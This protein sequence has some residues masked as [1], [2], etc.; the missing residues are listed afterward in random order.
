MRARQPRSLAIERILK[1]HEVPLPDD[2]VLEDPEGSPRRHI[3]GKWYESPDGHTY[4]SYAMTL[5]DGFPEIPIAWRRRAGL[6]LRPT[7]DLRGPLLDGGDADRLARNVACL[8]WSVARVDAVAYRFD[9]EPEIDD[10]R[11]VTVD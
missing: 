8:D 4:R 5:D 6:R 11:F 7:T 9:G 3:R 2:F 10:A 1:G